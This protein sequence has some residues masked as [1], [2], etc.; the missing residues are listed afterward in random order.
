MFKILNFLQLNSLNFNYTVISN[1]CQDLKVRF[2]LLISMLLSCKH[3]HVVCFNSSEHT[4]RDVNST[5]QCY[6][7]HFNYGILLL[8]LVK[9]QLKYVAI[10]CM[11]FVDIYFSNGLLYLSSSHFNKFDT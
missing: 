2:P 4:V 1:S 10:S 3:L 6:L 9:K 8:I 5:I 7:K 11:V